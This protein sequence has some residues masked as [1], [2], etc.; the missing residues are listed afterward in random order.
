MRRRAFTATLLAAALSLTPALAEGATARTGGACAVKGRQV[1][2]GKA[3]LQCVRRSGHLRWAKVTPLP[4]PVKTYDPLAGGITVFAAA[5]LTESFNALGQQFAKLHPLVNVTL[6]FGASST[7]ATQIV[8]GAPADV[9]ASASTTNMQQ[10]VNARLVTNPVTFARNRLIIVTPP[11][12]PKGITSVA[13]LA[14]AGVKVAV[15]QIQ[16]PC[17]VIA[18]QVFAKAGVAVTPVTYEVDVKSVLTKVLLGEVDAGLVYVTDAHSAGDR[19]A[20]IV[21]PPEINA[22]TTY[23]IGRLL[24]SGNPD[25]AQAFI[26]FVLSDRG[27]AALAVVGFTVL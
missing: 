4:L 26:D 22:E 1:H 17:G 25:A 3:V 11:G 18:K 23:P 16:V 13:D 27:A 15:C 10:T 19:V 9:F 14:K 5:S 7:L 21:I 24:G 20:S 2:V 12:N 6:S 8:Q